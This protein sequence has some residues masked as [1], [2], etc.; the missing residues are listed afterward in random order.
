[1][2]ENVNLQELE[3]QVRELQGKLDACT[4]ENKKLTEE[5]EL[6]AGINQELE[7]KVNELQGKLDASVQETEKLTQE[8]GK[9]AQENGKLAQELE[10][11]RERITMFETLPEDAVLKCLR[12][13]ALVSKAEYEALKDLYTRKSQELN[14]ILEEKEQKFAKEMANQRA[15]L[16]IELRDSRQ[17]SQDY[18]TDSVKTFSD[19]YNYYLSQVKL[20]MDTLSDVATQTGEEL[21]TGENDDLKTRIG[22]QIR[23]QLATDADAMKNDGDLLLFGSVKEEEAQEAEEVKEDVAEETDGAAEN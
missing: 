18:V 2:S 19:S 16:E 21:F 23:E 7:A 12:D 3:A 11:A 5:Y 4:E 15:K 13:E 8:N 22:H 14:G 1:M 17:A 10:A 9:L 6:A 20:L